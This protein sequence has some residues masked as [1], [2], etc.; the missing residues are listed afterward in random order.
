MM[1]RLEYLE[2]EKNFYNPTTTT[3]TKTQQRTQFKNGPI[4]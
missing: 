3:Q 4:L 2:Y 1:K